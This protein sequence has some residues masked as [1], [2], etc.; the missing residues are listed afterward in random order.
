MARL[1]LGAVVIRIPIEVDGHVG[2]DKQYF[3]LCQEP[4]TVGHALRVVYGT[5]NCK[6]RAA[7]RTKPR[8]GSGRRALRTLAK[9]DLETLGSLDSAPV[10][11]SLSQSRGY[12]G[13]F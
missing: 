11:M 8:Q 3:K 13:D 12:L 10:G 9:Q 5:A 4:L 2:C 1:I 7:L 6:E